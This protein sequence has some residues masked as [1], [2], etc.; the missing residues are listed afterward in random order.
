MFKIFRQMHHCK[1]G[2]HLLR[3]LVM[4]VFSWPEASPTCQS[5]QDFSCGFKLS[6]GLQY[7]VQRTRYWVPDHCIV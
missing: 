2:D 1:E 7:L 3:Q 5:W 6:E 4:M